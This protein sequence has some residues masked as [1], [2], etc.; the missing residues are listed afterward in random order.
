M[1]RIVWL[2]A[3]GLGWMLVQRSRQRGGE[4]AGEEDLADPDA[5]ALAPLSPYP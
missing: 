1:R 5:E 4:A 2:L 3:M